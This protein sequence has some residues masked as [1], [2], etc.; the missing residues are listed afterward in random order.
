MK[1]SFFKY[2]LFIIIVSCGFRPL[3]KSLNDDGV[4]YKTSKIQ[5]S[6]VKNFD[7]A[8]GI[9]LRNKL[10]SKIS[11]YGM[12]SNTEYVLDINLQEPDI[13]GYTIN[14]DGTTSSYNVAIKADYIL[15][16]KK[17]HSTVIQNEVH[18]ETNYS[19]L[20]SQL[21]T[22]SLKQEAIKLAIENLAEQIYFAMVSY[23]SDN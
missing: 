12:N 5:I 1:I 3:Y 19:V 21:A 6:P 15:K 16:R 7:G 9:E 22:E 11:P 18:A 14:R 2:L 8:Y 20:Q 4:I 10:F 23:F 17:D 13:K